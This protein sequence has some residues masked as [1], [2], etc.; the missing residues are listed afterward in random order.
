MAAM[1]LLLFNLI[2]GQ[3]LLGYTVMAFVLF[4]AMALIPQLLGHTSFN[5]AL[6]FLPAAFVVAGGY[7]RAGRGN[8]FSHAV[9]SGVSGAVGDLGQYFDPEWG[10]SGWPGPG[11]VQPNLLVT[12]PT[13][14]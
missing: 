5:W 2:G 1:T 7:Q 14:Y 3:D 4:L 8:Y 10:L 9:I 12:W 13:I 11:V 6:G